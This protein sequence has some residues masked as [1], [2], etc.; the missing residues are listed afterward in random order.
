MYSGTL[1]I[2]FELYCI[3]LYAAQTNGCTVMSVGDDLVST[4]VMPQFED[5]ENRKCG[6][7]W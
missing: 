7:S 4:A 6:R 1:E 3:T 2:L 5:L